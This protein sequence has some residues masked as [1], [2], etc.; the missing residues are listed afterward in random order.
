VILRA[1]TANIA[2]FMADAYEAKIEGHRVPVVNVPYHYASDTAHAMLK[3]FPDAPFTA[4]WFRRGDG[5]IQWSLRSEDSEWTFLRSP[6]REAAAVI[7]TLLGFK[8]PHQ[9]A[10]ERADNH[11]LTSN[12][13]PMSAYYNEID[14]HAAQWI[15]NLID[16]GHIA[17]GDVDE[18]SIRDVLATDLRGY[19]QC[20]FFAGIG[21]WSLA[22]RLAGWP[23]DEPVWTGSCPCQPFSEAGRRNAFNDERDLWPTWRGLISECRPPIVFGEQ[24]ATGDGVEWA[25]RTGAGFEA[26]GYA[27][28][29]AVLPAYAVGS[30]QKRERFYIAAHAIGADAGRRPSD[31]WRLAIPREVEGVGPL[32][33]WNGGLSRYGRLADGLP[34][35]WQSLSPGALATPSF[36][37]SLP[38][39]SAP[40]RNAR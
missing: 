29:A 22:L 6:K 2:K 11:A 10:R 36:P 16:A 8:S 34:A 38:R 24:V 23:D 30:N 13:K 9:Q 31:R 33:T 35:V 19:T 18:R 27:F 20:H 15:R 39:S 3:A 28:G 21:G 4:C 12:S 7:A 40:R 26:E 5:M 1:H 25:D 17:A 14:P 32:E 37:N